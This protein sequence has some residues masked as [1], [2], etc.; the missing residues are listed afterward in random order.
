MNGFDMNKLES[1]CRERW[2]TLFEANPSD[3]EKFYIT[4]A[5]PYPSGAMHVGHG[6]TYMVPDVI[7][8][9]WR[10]RGKQVLYPMAFHVT[11]APVIGISKR[12]A[13]GDEAAIHLYRDLYRVP[14][15]V[16]DQF[17]D[18]L[19]IVNHFSN[20]Y[21]RVMRMCGLSIDWRRRFTTVDPT[22]SKF[23]EWQF[24]HLYNDGHVA[25]G[26]HPVRYCPQDDN[27][28]G[29][30]DLLEGEKA[31]VIKFTLVM[32]QSEEG[33]IPTATL[34]PETI[35]GV[36]NLWVNPTVTY[37]KAEV[38]GVV[39]IVSREA[40]DKLAMQDHAVK[41]IGE[42]PGSA[43]VD[44]MVTHPLA[45]QVRILPADFVDPDMATGIVMSV[46]A[47]APFDYIA[48]RDLQQQG[49][50]TDIV[51]VPLITVEGYGKVPAKDAV[52]RA[53]ITNQHDVRMEALTQEVY[54]AEFAKGKLYPEYGG[55]PVRV[56]RDTVADLMLAEYGSAVMYEFDH[57]P[58]ICRCGS[59][60]YVKILH[61]QWFLKYSDPVWK[62]QVHEHLPRIKLVPTEV[63]AE[64]ERT[65]DWLKDWACTRRVGLGT[66]VPWDPTWLFEPLS[67]STIYMAYYTIAHRIREI[68]PALLT[69]AVFDYIFLGTE[70]PD[71]PI[72][73]Q[74]DALRAEFMY[75]YPYDFRFSAKDLISNHL[76]FQVFHHV[77][78]FPEQYQPKGIVVFGMGL[79]NG[80]KMSSSKGNVFL[81]EDAVQ[82][83]GADTVRMFLMGSAEPWQDFD[84][85][86]ELVASTRKQI[87]RFY[88]TVTEGMT[89]TGDQTPIDAWLI[90]RLQR[91]IQKTTDALELFQTRQALQESFFAIEAD[92]K[93]Y[94]RRVPAGS[95]CNAAIRE[96][97][98]VWVRLLAP[99][100]PFT[101][102]ALWHQMGE[103]GFVSVA[104]WPVPQ[105][106]KILP[107]VELA[108]ELLARTV[109]DIESIMKL[110]QIT[111]SSIEIAV[112]PAWKQQ[113]FA[114]IASSSDRKAGV[115][116]VM[117]NEEMRARGKAAAET[118]K[119]CITLVH[120]LPP[121][122]IEQLLTEAPDE[123]ALFY[124]AQGFLE[125]SFG[126]PVKIVGAEE[127]VHTKAGSAL[128]FKPAIIIE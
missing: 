45:G 124:A 99:F 6:R 126:I 31:E 108:E 93:W 17:T 2:G 4:V 42:I 119:Q 39:W 13:R 68:D 81:L 52:E 44:Q 37:V 24:S 47:H 36:T 106:E 102:E 127:S 53:N 84:W 63:R 28:V 64:F 12:I 69:P 104:P 5:Y 92:L 60:V 79:L 120:R 40:A 19:A 70:S 113:V 121:Q 8:R 74:L 67:D 87:E 49:Q 59:R 21:E 107:S 10:M 50:Y 76:T 89:V 51:P 41:V 30:H 1:E 46:P 43:L 111:P 112:A 94:W 117:K 16:L 90:S 91:H 85:R 54:S 78:I 71:L 128:P 23:V 116:E 109:E 26:A 11:G 125:E 57:R 95:A 61:D 7:A 65:V 48:L 110:I 100:I 56:A 15:Q 3:K 123:L 62:E 96:L 105:Q 80:A 34:R 118:A 75:W 103:E 86:N 97:C 58:V 33:L 77:A 9:F 73:E 114:L 20:E 27:P 83:F 22:Y 35:Y 55:A 82:E 38:D 18:P 32:Y 115:G 72:R 98:Q 29:D 14:Q 66:K 25:K 122:L 88:A 101:C